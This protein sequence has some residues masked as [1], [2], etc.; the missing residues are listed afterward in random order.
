MAQRTIDR[1]LKLL[2]A[3]F[4]GELSNAGLFIE[5]DGDGGLVVAK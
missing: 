5:F 2:I 3:D 1:A 4:T